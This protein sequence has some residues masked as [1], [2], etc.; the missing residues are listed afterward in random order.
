MSSS[1]LKDVQAHCVLV[2]LATRLIVGLSYMPVH[3]ITLRPACFFSSLFFP[4][5]P[6]EVFLV[7]RLD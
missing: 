3:Y 6:R 2:S 5:A 7:T 4:V 1:V